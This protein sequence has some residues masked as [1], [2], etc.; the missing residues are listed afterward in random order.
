MR[1]SHKE[2]ISLLE[3]ISTQENV[4]SKRPLLSTIE[5]DF[6]MNEERHD[7]PQENVSISTDD[8]YDEDGT[9]D[10]V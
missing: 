2:F 4:I 6:S 9:K 5:A 3:L 10:V 1:S 8:K 7:V